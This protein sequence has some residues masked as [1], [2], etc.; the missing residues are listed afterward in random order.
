M[1]VITEAAA[2]LEVNE[3]LGPSLFVAMLDMAS[4]IRPVPNE[5]HRLTDLT[6]LARHDPEYPNHS[7]AFYMSCFAWNFGAASVPVSE[8]ICI[9][10]INIYSQ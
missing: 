4:N 6:I 5:S 1:M 10:I 7:R 9:D 8:L 2:F 3:N